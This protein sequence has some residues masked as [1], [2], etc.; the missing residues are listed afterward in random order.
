[1][2]LPDYMLSIVFKSR[3]TL[4]YIYTNTH[5]YTHIN[6]HLYKSVCK[7]SNKK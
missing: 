4:M 7:D 2:I 6:I 1:M 5:T 3:H